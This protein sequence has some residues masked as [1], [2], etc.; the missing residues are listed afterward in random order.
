MINGDAT[1]SKFGYR[2]EDISEGSNRLV[3]LTC[4]YCGADISASKKVRNKSNTF[5]P[6]D[7]C[8]KCRYVKR[9]DVSMA[10]DGVSNSA[11]REDVRAKLSDLNSER[12]KSPQYKAQIKETM[13]ERYGAESALQVP[14]MAA[15]QRATMLER[16]GAQY[17]MQIDSYRD[18]IVKKS[19]ETKIAR[20]TIKTHEGKT[21]PQVAKSQ[22]FSR[23]HFGKMIAKHGIDYALS[24]EKGRTYIEDIFNI[25]LKSL[26]VDYQEQFR[27]DNRIADFRVGNIIIE[28]DGLRWHSDIYLPD[29]YHV[30]KRQLY[31]SHGYRPLFFRENEISNKFEI[32][33]SIALN[34]LGLCPH[35]IGA[36]E[37]SIAEIPYLQAKKFIEENHLMGPSTAISNSCALM[38]GEEIVSMLQMKKGKDNVYEIGRFC[39]RLGHSVPGAFTRLLSYFTKSY[40]PSEVYTFI[41]LRYGQGEYLTKLGF[42]KKSEYPSFLWT[43]GKNVFHRMKFKGSSGYENGLNKI[44][45]CGQVKHILSC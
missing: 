1:L 31:I 24:L 12:L 10:R 23:S 2:F 38:R 32:V 5:C 11:Q 29:N 22:G 27:I 15:Q 9:A 30:K 45:D 25:F 39:N 26:N 42:I 8:N 4:D 3:M 34:A 35:K 33:K 20:G 43:D 7:A 44:W 14:E 16:Y 37:L 41:D 28:C 40:K 6:K 17:L 18:K 21:M 13:I 19:I 36:R